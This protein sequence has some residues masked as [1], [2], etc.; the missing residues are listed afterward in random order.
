MPLI[1]RFLL[2]LAAFPVVAQSGFRFPDK[3][4]RVIIPFEFINNLIVIPVDVNGVALNFLLDTGVDETILFSLEDREVSFNNV[5]RVKLKGLGSQEA[6]EGLK[7]SG[8]VLSVKNALTDANHELYIILDTDLNLSVDVGVPV[9]GILGYQFFKEHLVEVDYASQRIVI[10]P[11]TKKIR[12]RLARHYKALSLSI[13]KNKPYVQ[14]Q[15]VLDG[16]TINTKLLLDTG[17]SDAVWLFDNGADIRVPGNNFEDYLGK[18]FSGEIHGRRA[19]LERFSMG[20]FAF[21]HPIAAF[22]D[23]ASIRNLSLVEDRVGSVGGEVLKRFTTVYDYP[24]GRVFL[25]PND[26]IASPFHYNMSGME[27]HHVGVTW[28]RESIRMKSAYMDNNYDVEGNKQSEFIYKVVLKP[29]FAVSSV[30]PG[31]PAALAGVQKN[32]Q[33]VSINGKPGHQ[34]KLQEI[35]SLLKSHS[36]RTIQMEVE[37]DG[38]IRKIQFTLKAIL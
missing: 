34:Y 29:V 16:K 10:H 26:M 1:Y 21:H 28:V 11:D 15:T 25:K 13:E 24:N 4:R 14:A 9:N 8:N 35:F 36:G 19:R 27:I 5:Q 7:S 30:R 17:N 31:S 18:G 22:P 38:Q 6:V 23:S 2:F 33:V 3:Q 20:G 12:R 32:D 37:R